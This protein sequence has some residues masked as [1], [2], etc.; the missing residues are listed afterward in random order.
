MG[1]SRRA[2]LTLKDS[3]DLARFLGQSNELIRFRAGCHKGFFNNNCNN[4]LL[5]EPITTE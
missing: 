4:E 1:W 5:S 3:Q 2:A